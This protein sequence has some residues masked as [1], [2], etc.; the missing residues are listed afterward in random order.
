MAL[1]AVIPKRSTDT[2]PPT[3][4]LG[5]LSNTNQALITTNRPGIESWAVVP[6]PHTWPTVSV[7]GG[8]APAK[9]SS[10]TAARTLP[11]IAR[12]AKTKTPGS[13]EETPVWDTAGFRTVKTV[14][15]AG[16]LAALLWAIIAGLIL[17]LRSRAVKR[18]Q[19]TP[20]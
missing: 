4:A 20:I 6:V 5:P 8:G 17:F 1:P 12:A 19:G 2:V 16:Y 3:D 13:P 9:G 7:T 14:A 15:V 11:T 18:S 10:N